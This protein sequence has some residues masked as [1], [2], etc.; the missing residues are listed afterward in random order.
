MV[1]DTKVLEEEHS[2]ALILATTHTDMLVAERDQIVASLQV[3][4]LRGL[5]SAVPRGQRRVLEA[6]LRTVSTEL[7]GITNLNRI[8][9]LGYAPFKPNPK[10]VLGLADEDD[11][12]VV[13]HEWQTGTGAILVD[14]G[15]YFNAPMPAEV[16]TKWAQA[17]STGLFDLFMVSSPDSD[18][19]ATSRPRPIWTADPI[20]IG[21][22]ATRASARISGFSGD[23]FS[24]LANAQNVVGFLIAQWDLQHD[25]EKGG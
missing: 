2:K 18:Q 8:T 4:K 16:I 1:V 23:Q 7:R 17:R 21:F 13:D 6:R 15:R 19:F 9:E 12:V 20:L 22:I 11:R 10:W 14:S 24:R 25:L 3:R 5:R